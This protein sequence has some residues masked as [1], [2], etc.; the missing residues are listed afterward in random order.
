MAT[1][2]FSRQREAILRY[3][4]S[5][6]SHPTAELVYNEV[7]KSYPQVSLGTVY[8]NLN[9]LSENGSILRLQ[10]GDGSEHFDATTAS[11]PHLF[12]RECHSLIDL[13]GAVKPDLLSDI[14]ADYRGRLESYSLMCFGLCEHCADLK[15]KINDKKEDSYG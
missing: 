8:R 7:R 11:H 12:C 3:L 14:A 10:C 2:K 4:K 9:L 1:T 5:T 13:P 6:T 15:R